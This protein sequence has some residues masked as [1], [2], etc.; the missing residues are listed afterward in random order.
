MLGKCWKIEKNCKIL[1]SWG[2]RRGTPWGTPRGTPR[3]APGVP[4]GERS[5]DAYGCCEKVARGWK[6]EML[7][8]LKQKPWWLLQ[9]F[10]KF[11]K[12]LQ[13]FAKLCKVLQN[14][15]APGGTIWGCLRVLWSRIHDDKNDDL[16]KEDISIGISNTQYAAL[17]RSRNPKNVT[18][19]QQ[20]LP[21]GDPAES[22]GTPKYA[23]TSEAEFMMTKMTIY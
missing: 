9:N 19:L 10:A 15:A 4:L 17:S 7:K 11:C 20:Y 21:E 5:G 13:S 14:F 8:Y 18:K 16:L 3:G 23:K 1:Q 22:C 2:Y 12:V 6:R